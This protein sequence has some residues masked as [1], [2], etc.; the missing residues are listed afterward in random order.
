MATLDTLLRQNPAVLH[1]VTV[2]LERHEFVCRWVYGLPGFLDWI[3]DDL[4]KLQ[5]GRLRASET[6]QEQ[7]DFI[8]Y[9][10]VAGKT[11][12][13]DKMFKD[14]MPA[15]DGVWELKT[16]DLRIFGWMYR[17]RKFIAVFADYADLYK[18]TAA[19]RSYLSAVKRVKTARDYLD[20]DQP[21]IAT[22]S[23]FDDLV[24]I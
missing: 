4:P 21:K 13:Y 1:N 11:V 17:P 20:L 12:R 18:G 23:K 10:W 7:F 24:C 8:L 15:A 6:P 2:P 22:E 3:K 19:K 9:K 5:T 14:L 16:V